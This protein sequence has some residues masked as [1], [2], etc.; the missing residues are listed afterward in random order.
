VPVSLSIKNVPEDVAAQLR[1]RAKAHRRSLQ[2]ELLAIVEQAVAAPAELTPAGLKAYVDS[3]GLLTDD[4]S[5]G[6]I[7]TDRD[8]R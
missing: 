7:R 1:D 8:G 2:G 5:V 6:I 3:L 4:D